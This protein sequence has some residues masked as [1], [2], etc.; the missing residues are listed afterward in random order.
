MKNFNESFQTFEEFR[1][2][3]QPYGSLFFHLKDVENY[4]DQAVI[5]TPIE[6][7]FFVK[8]SII[9]MYENHKTVEGK[10]KYLL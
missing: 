9:E 4:K 10:L 7:I 1:S 6:N 8:L 3:A 2:F 5:I